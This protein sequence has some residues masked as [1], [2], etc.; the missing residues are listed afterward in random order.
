VPTSTATATSTAAPTATATSTGVPTA[1]VT[2]TITPLPSTTAT[3][4]PVPTATAT[5]TALPTSTATT[6]PPPAPTVTAT[7][8]PVVGGCAG[9]VAIP[10]AGGTF[11]G[12]TAGTSTLAGSCADTGSA[13]ERVFAWTPA[14]SGAATIQTCSGT[15]TSYDSVLYVRSLD[16]ATG[17]E[18]ACNDDSAGCFTSEPNDH[19][20]SRIVTNV[21]AG[22]TYFIV[23]DGYATSRGD[24]SVT[25]TPPDASGPSP[26]PTPVTGACQNP[27]V[28]P[29]AGG[30][31]AGTT[32]GASSLAGTCASSNAAPERVYQWTPTASGTA[33]IQTCDGAGTG[34]D[35]VLYLRH[36]DCAGGVQVSCNDDSAG[37]F[38][39]EPNDHHASR[40]TPNVV[41]G[42]TYFIVVDGYGSGQGA[43]NLSVSPPAAGGPAAT[44]TPVTTPVVLPT[45]T[46]V[47]TT[48]ALPTATVAGAT[49]TGGA[50]VP[51]PTSTPNGTCAAPIALPAAGGTFSGTTSGASAVAG[52]CASSNLAPEVVYA[53][54]PTRSGTAFIN[55][56]GSGTSYDTVMYVRTGSCAA[57]D[58]AC[59]DDT[60]GC[61]TSEPSTYHGSSVTLTV[62]AGQTYLIVVDGYADKRGS[63]SL[64]VTS[65]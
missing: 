63:F 10:A 36:G 59:N 65:P 26:T 5:I 38:T 3:T 18:V 44:A 41:A 62:T 32:A 49:P 15:G 47:P 43:F 39:N 33:T 14:V 12:T 40:L 8:G 21:V 50:P 31:F 7:P 4:T 29:A 17:P 55:T 30:S 6:T 60:Q 20:A 28:I 51:T 42:E 9:A 2:A 24:F 61:G 45:T 53:W 35:T 11:T 27:T 52:T 37:C 1:T 34:Y 13:P 46:P 48:T 16:C 56:C 25:V 64:T 19:H 58:A 54:T 57:A 22:R 23:V